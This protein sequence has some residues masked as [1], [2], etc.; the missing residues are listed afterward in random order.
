MQN[1]SND[2][3]QSWRQRLDELEDISGNDLDL[4]AAWGKLQQKKNEIKTSSSKKWY[5]LAAACI[6]ALLLTLAGLFAD[7][8]SPVITN[9][10]LVKA[11]QPKAEKENNYSIIQNTPAIVEE[12]SPVNRVQAENEPAGVLK[13][14]TGNSLEPLFA[15]E[16]INDASPVIHSPDT[17]ATQP[18]PVATVVAKKLKVVHINELNQSQ[19]GIAKEEGKP[20]FPITYQIREVYTNADDNNKK[21]RSD[22]IR[23]KLN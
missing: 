8:R 16:V 15:K 17:I 12:K 1:N 14:I 3:T 20:Y 22:L 4:N 7:N 6:A 21:G 5:W 9:P 23:I 19:Q 11:E 18:L 10:G 2:S 13:T